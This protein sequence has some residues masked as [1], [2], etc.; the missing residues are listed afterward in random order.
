VSEWTDRSE[1]TKQYFFLEKRKKV[2]K[3]IVAVAAFQSG[4]GAVEDVPLAAALTPGTR[5]GDFG[6][7]SPLLCSLPLSPF[8]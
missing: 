2:K 5:P 4:G 3:T 6:R 8:P 7:Y 1:R